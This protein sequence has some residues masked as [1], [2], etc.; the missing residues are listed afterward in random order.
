MSEVYFEQVLELLQVEED[1]TLVFY[2]DDCALVRFAL[3]L[4]HVTVFALNSED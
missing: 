1:A 2:D 3:P 4:P